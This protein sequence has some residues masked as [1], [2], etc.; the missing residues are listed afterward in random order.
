MFY[1]PQTKGFITQDFMLDVLWMLAK[2]SPL[3][4]APSFRCPCHEP[5]RDVA[6]EEEGRGGGR[7][8]G[9]PL[10]LSQSLR[11]PCPY[12]KGLW[13]MHH[14]GSMIRCGMWPPI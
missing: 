14:V 3:T 7:G 2:L 6:G 9:G 10:G 1:R 13:S 12:S 8:G 11:S 5:C 4:A